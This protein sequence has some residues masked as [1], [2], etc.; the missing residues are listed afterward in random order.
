MRTASPTMP[1]RFNTVV[2]ILVGL[3][4]GLAALGLG[5]AVADAGSGAGSG[6]AI[7]SG[8]AELA[9]ALPT[10]DTNDGGGLARSLY[11]AARDGRYKIATGFLLMLAVFVLRTYVVGRVAW[12]KT[13]L[14]GIALAMATGIGS[15]VGLAL[16]AGISPRVGDILNAAGT[17]LTAAG[18]WEWAKD[19]I[20][21]KTGT[22]A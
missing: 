14:G 17:A 11:D 10:I 2:F 7:G 16:A 12:F 21:K 5:V 20:A 3:V 4:A 9:A 6:S 15:V 18:A 8:Q 22:S 13:K 19:I 1:S